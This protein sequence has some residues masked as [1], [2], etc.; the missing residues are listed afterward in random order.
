MKKNVSILLIVAGILFI[1][2][3]L[4]FASGTINVKDYIKGKLPSVFSFYLSSLE[5][6]DSYWLHAC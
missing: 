1:L 4:I 2:S 3:T 6:L 5:D